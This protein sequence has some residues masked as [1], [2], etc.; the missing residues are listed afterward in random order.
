LV[1][2]HLGP[3]RPRSPCD[4]L[5]FHDC[6]VHCIHLPERADASLIASTPPMLEIFLVSLGTLCKIDASTPSSVSRVAE[7]SLAATMPVESTNMERS[8]RAPAHTLHRFRDG[9]GPLGRRTLAHHDDVARGSP[10]KVAFGGQAPR[11]VQD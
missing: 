1:T 5:A 8:G 4:Y 6:A 9:G 3:T 2:A 7:L 11:N 10:E